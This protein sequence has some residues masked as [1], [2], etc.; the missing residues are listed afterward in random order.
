MKKILALLLAVVMVFSLA[1]CGNTDKTP[2]ENPEV[3]VTTP[4]DKDP[5]EETTPGVKDET[6]DDK[7]QLPEDNTFHAFVVNVGYA[8]AEKIEEYAHPSSTQPTGDI[9]YPVFVI[10][11]RSDLDLFI[12]RYREILRLGSEEDK[13]S[14]IYLTSIY[15]NEFFEANSLMLA[16]IASSSGSITYKV[17]SMELNN[18]HMNMN[19]VAEVP[20]VGTDDMAGRLAVARLYNDIIVACDSFTASRMIEEN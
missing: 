6:D 16:Y 17:D 20:E 5:V 10:R 13:N 18:T 3:E 4:A 1:A 19:I 2:T 9:N 8:D 15:D 14:F 7:P 11:S 12:E